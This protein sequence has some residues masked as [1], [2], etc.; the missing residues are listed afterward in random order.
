M[1]D[2]PTAACG[3]GPLERG[4]GPQSAV[5]AAAAVGRSGPQ[6]NGKRGIPTECAGCAT[7][8]HPHNLTA[9]CA[10]C[11]LVARNRRLSRH[12]ADLSDPVTLA[13][14]ITNAT[15]VLGAHIINT[16]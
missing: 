8:L 2:A 4:R 9:L 11:K 6:W 14:A 3:R 15:K 7:P 10:E 12:P 5:T 16:T 13:D 1:T